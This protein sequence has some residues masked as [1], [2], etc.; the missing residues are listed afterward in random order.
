M[1]E[2]RRAVR[3]PA[4]S[5]RRASRVYFVFLPSLYKEREVWGPVGACWT[6]AVNYYAIFIIPMLC[7][8][9]AC[10]CVGTTSL[11]GTCHSLCFS[12]LRPRRASQGLQKLAGVI[13]FE[14]R[15]EGNRLRSCVRV[16]MPVGHGLGE[17]LPR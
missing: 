2:L 8:G 16:A 1:T 3:A 15:R 12:W 14:P 7:F 17:G 6:D 9:V 13:T 4:I 11:W 5:R 10:S